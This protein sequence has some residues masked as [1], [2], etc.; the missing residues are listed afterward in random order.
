MPAAFIPPSKNLR[1]N[2]VHNHTTE[3]LRNRRAYMLA[4]LRD[5]AD[6]RMEFAY[7][8][9]ELQAIENVLVRRGHLCVTE[10][11]TTPGNEQSTT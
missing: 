2:R 5:I 3:T 8:A 9:Y 11:R 10:R 6:S 7:R 1:R 4:N